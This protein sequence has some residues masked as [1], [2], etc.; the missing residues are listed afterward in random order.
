MVCYRVLKLG[1]MLLLSPICFLQMI[2]FFLVRFQKEKSLNL[3]IMEMYCMVS[4]QCINYEKSAV[5]FSKYVSLEIRTQFCNSFQMV[6]VDDFGTYLGMPSIIGRDK[7]N[8]FKCI[9][10]RIWRRLSSWTMQ[11]LSKAGKEILIKAVV[12]A[13]PTYLMSCFKLPISLVAEIN[14]MVGKFWWSKMGNKKA[15]HWVVGLIFVNL[16]LMGVLVFKILRFLMTR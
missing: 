11:F 1:E 16:N 5:C 6:L 2:V 15:I 12:Q 4:G 10:D 7:G 8:A 13:I 9:K 14:R 3:N